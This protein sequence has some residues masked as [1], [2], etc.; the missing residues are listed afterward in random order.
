MPVG[1]SIVTVDGIDAADAKAV[2][3][4]VLNN[5]NTCTAATAVALRR[6]HGRRLAADA[7]ASAHA[8]AGAVCSGRQG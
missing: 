8:E 6:C 7:R 2:D 1:R 4:A 3:D 5:A